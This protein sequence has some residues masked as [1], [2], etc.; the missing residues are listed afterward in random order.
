MNGKG[1]KPRNCF[2]KDYKS[3]YDEINWNT[4]SESNFKDSKETNVQDKRNLQNVQPTEQG[5]KET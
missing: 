4:S 2:S 1:D 3:N 5:C